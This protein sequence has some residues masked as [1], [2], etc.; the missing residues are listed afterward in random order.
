MLAD[1]DCGTPWLR[2]FSTCVDLIRTLPSLGYDQTRVED[3]AKSDLDHWFDALRYAVMGI[4]P[5]PA[6]QAPGTDREISGRHA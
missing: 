6:N 5:M 1:C 4:T 3:V 2:V